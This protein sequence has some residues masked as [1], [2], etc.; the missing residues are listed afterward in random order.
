MPSLEWSGGLLGVR[1]RLEPK[2]ITELYKTYLSAISSANSIKKGTQSVDQ[3]KKPIALWPSTMSEFL[4]R[5][6]NSLFTI[7]AYTLDPTKLVDPK[8]CVASP[9]DLPKT[10]EFLDKDP[11]KGLIRIDEI[12]AQ[13]GFSDVGNKGSQSDSDSQQ[14]RGRTDKLKLSTQLR[15]YY[16][17]HLNPSDSPELSDVNALQAIEDA[18]TIFDNR[19]RTSF[20]KALNEVEGMGYPGIDDPKLIISTKISPMDGLN[21]SSAVLFEV[22]DNSGS[23][24][25]PLRLPEQYNGLGYQNLI[26]MVFKLLSFRDAWMLVGK[27]EKKTTES[28]ED[29]FLPPLHLVMLEEPEAH[30]HAQVQQVF[31]R[32]AYDIL[33]K[34]DNLGDKSN[35]TT[36]LVVSTHQSHSS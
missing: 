8:E 28:N 6:L 13:R 15:S 21:H 30:L 27:A 5:K 9:Q 7:R 14:N 16:D 11:L 12:K 34:H 32:K 22:I 10:S 2:D 31:I 35:F 23:Q 18:Q 1:L 36:Q 29:V 20:E 3:G 17:K 25:I 26:S 33:R 24:E 19:L 4:D